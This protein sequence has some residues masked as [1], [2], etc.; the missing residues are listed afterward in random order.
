MGVAD[1]ARRAGA[2]P[3]VAV[4]GRCLLDDEQLHGAGIRAAYSLSDLEPDLDTSIRDAASLLARVGEQIARDWLG[5]TAG[6]DA[7]GPSPA[8]PVH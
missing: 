6:S 3:V 2:T 8:R 7:R 5:P 4:A 1:A